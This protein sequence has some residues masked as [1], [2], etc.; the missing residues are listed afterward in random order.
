MPL[1]CVSFQETAHT[2]AIF[3]MWSAS[4]NRCTR[5]FRFNLIIDMLGLS[6]LFTFLVSL[7]PLFSICFLFPVFLSAT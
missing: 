3:P 4:F 7:F 5:L 1:A 2:W 6:L